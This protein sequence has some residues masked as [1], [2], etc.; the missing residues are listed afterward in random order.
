MRHRTFLGRFAAGSVAFTLALTGATFFWVVTAPPAHA[1]VSPVVPRPAAAVTA[2]PLPT[3]QID[4]IVWT[5]TLHGNTVYAGGS[6]THAR[7]AGAAAGTNQTTRR[8]LLAYDI[9][10]GK[11][12]TGFNPAPN[13]VVKALAVSPDGSRLYVGGSF[14]SIAGKSRYR[15]AAFNT[16]TGALVG[17]FAPSL[18]ATVTAIAATN[19]T[20]YA[21][22][23]FGVANGRSRTR[24][25]AFRASDGAL[26]SWAPTADADIT[27]LVLTPN[28]KRLVVGGS[29]QHLSGQSD[30]GI[31]SVSAST[32]KILSWPVNK[33]IRNGNS[34]S[35]TYSLSTDND[36]VY[37]TSYNFG[38][39]NYEGEFA[40]HQDGTIKWLADCHGDTYAAFSVNNIVYGSGHQHF[41]SNI[42]GFPEQSPRV[43][44]HLM[45]FTKPA[46]GTVRKNSELG[47]G[48]GNFQGQPSPSIIDYFPDFTT[49]NVSGAHQAVWS[50]TGNTRYLA[51]GGEFPTAGGAAQQGLVRFAISSIAPNKIGVKDLGGTTNPSLDVVS[52]QGVRVSWRLN[53]D[54]DDMS[55]TYRVLRQDRAT[56][57]LTAVTR[58]STW[59]RRPVRSYL[60]TS[61]LPG[62]TYRYRVTVK[63]A[64][65][66]G[67]ISDWITV[68]VPA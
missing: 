46:T 35:G 6:F 3:V 12:K 44:K 38:T 2:D 10:T 55:L 53:W 47:S 22:G 61:A 8:N 40:M 29:F 9:T 26:L 68:S 54:P 15:I 48:Y 45:A 37:A 50:L 57:A 32:G 14:T 41:C 30:M 64:A 27:S 23:W 59:W 7:P 39:G 16:S 42:G 58:R 60:D 36:T 56:A 28:G 43:E 5:Q 4:G 11:L 63:D 31:G 1:A 17:S 65:G 33:V 52:G 21:A 19:G 25:A 34:K 51:A 62:H 18:N 66:N 49:A 13:A 24:L 20:V 67:T